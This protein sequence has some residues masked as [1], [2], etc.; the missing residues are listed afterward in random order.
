MWDLGHKECWV[1]K[2]WCFQIVVKN[3]LESPLYCKE[4][5]PVSPKGNESWIFIGR[6]DAEA[7][8]PILGPLDAKSWLT[9]KKP[10]A[11]KDWGQEEKGTTEDEMIGWHHW[12]SGHEYEQ[13]LG[14]GEDR[15]AWCAAVHGVT[16]SQTWLSN[17]TTINVDDIIEFE[18][19][20]L[21]TFLVVQWLGLSTCKAG[22]QGS[23]PGQ[24]TGSQ[25]P[26]LRL[27]AAKYIN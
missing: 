7:E 19:N 4:I 12:L 21:G 11:G 16:K 27:S 5:K 2:N 14:D 15:E 17:W 26:Q 13:T 23:I 3:T 18:N 10:D 9:G 25:I 20:H 1:L 8:A 24:G 6:T 22:G